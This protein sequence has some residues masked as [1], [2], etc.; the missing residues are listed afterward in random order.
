MNQ[1]ID[2]PLTPFSSPIIIS[3]RIKLVQFVLIS[4]GWVYYVYMYWVYM[5]LC[6]NGA[7]YTGS[8]RRLGARFREH[9]GGLGAR[10][11]AR[12]LPV[13]LVWF[14]SHPSLS[15][16]L[17]REYQIKRLTHAEK[18]ALSL[19]K[20]EGNIF[21]HKHDELVG[22]NTQLYGYHNP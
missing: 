3:N 9:C 15:S 6:G 12:H 14:E 7:Y 10:Y 13:R 8:T 21:Y 4:S 1:S 19:K 5:L 16:A 2:N 17:K 22:H 18:G 20:P 11:T